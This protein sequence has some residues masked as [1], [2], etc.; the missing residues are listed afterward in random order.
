MQVSHCFTLQNISWNVQI[1]NLPIEIQLAYQGSTRNS[2]ICIHIRH[3]THFHWILDSNNFCCVIFFSVCLHCA[4]TQ[5]QSQTITMRIQSILEALCV[6]SNR[7]PSSNASRVSAVFFLGKR[8]IALQIIRKNST[9]HTVFTLL[10]FFAQFFTF[11][12]S[13]V[14][15]FDF[16]HKHTSERRERSGYARFDDLVHLSS[17]VYSRFSHFTL[18]NWI[19]AYRTLEWIKFPAS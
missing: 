8:F 9:A 15:L 17:V 5:Y 18:W 12:F 4:H 3:R 10:F 7:F 13:F 19:D 16:A 14:L 2:K 11:I 6:I 1:T